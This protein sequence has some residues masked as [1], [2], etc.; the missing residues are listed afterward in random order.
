LQEKGTNPFSMALRTDIASI[1]ALRITAA[2]HLLDC[3]L[4]TGLLVGWQLLRWL[5]PPVLPVVDRYSS[6]TVTAVLRRGMNQR[7]S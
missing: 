3:F 7:D 2:H 6:K 5:V 1:A 4:H